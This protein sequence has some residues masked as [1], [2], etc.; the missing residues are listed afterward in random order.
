MP[1]TTSLPSRSAALRTIGRFF[2]PF[3]RPLVAVAVLAI[4]GALLFAAEPLV[5]K[6]LFDEIGGAARIPAAAVLL[7]ALGGLLLVREALNAGLDWLVWRVRL[8]VNYRMLG[9]TVHRLHHLPLAHHREENVGAVMTKVERGITGS[10]AAFSEVAMH[11]VPSLVYLVASC[12]VMVRLDWRLSL[13]VVAFAPL[14]AIIGA[15][16]SREQIE[17]ERGLLARWT[18]IFARLNEVL[19]GI[20]VVKS[21]VMEEQ[22][23]RRFLRGVREAN[24]A[25]VRGVAT[26][27]RVNAAKNL[28][29]GFARVTAIA[30][31][32]LLVARHEISLGTLVAFLGYVAGVFMPVQ[33]LT[34]V[35][36]TVR[37]G[38]VSLEALMSIL[39][40]QDSL[41]D[42]PGARDPGPLRGEVELQDVR[43]EY[44]EGAPVLDGVSFRVRPGEM[45]ALVGPSG[46]GKSTVMALLQRLYDPTSGRVL[47]DGQDLR[48]LKQRAVRRQIGVV[49][50]EGTLFSDTVRDNIA[51]G[52][53]G[54]SQA[55]IEA[56]ARA[57][58]AHD[59]ILSLPDGYDT[60]VG[61]RGCKLSGGER[62]RVAIA[63]ALLKDAPILVLDEATSALDADSEERIKEALERLT[64]G[65]T[66]LVIAHRLATITRADRI[67]VF[68]GGRIVEEG[69]HRSLL[70]A[71]GYYASLV[72]KQTR[73][74]I[75]A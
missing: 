48:D 70:A 3:W 64:R 49:L 56:A 53:P 59:F 66:T 6:L 9:E 24:A 67:L 19:S 43:F 7:G 40:A 21:F 41:G 11:L 31:G 20:A 28:T 36:Q 16:A 22:E 52:R 4:V 62:Q 72:D 17:R 34:G 71:G 63:R 29:M 25:V 47:V 57:A 5:L 60:P 26:D 27:G 54:A 58:N 75:A 14:P 74:L 51:F 42:R 18:K 73:G 15:W 69:T 23:K 33:A 68:R 32:G 55:E 1:R 44:R 30:I 65:R 45:V 61:E 37:R 2:L 13:V 8:S 12:V 46:A 38:A 50:Q 35:Y 39:D 10:L